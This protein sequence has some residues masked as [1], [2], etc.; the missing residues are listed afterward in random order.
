MSVAP[1]KLMLFVAAVFALGIALGF[2][3]GRSSRGEAAVNACAE[4]GGQWHPYN[5]VCYG[6]RAYPFT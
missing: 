4:A 3:A 6:A 5:G 1:W 2:Y